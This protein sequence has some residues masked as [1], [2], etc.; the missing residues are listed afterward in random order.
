[1]KK[2]FL[3]ILLPF[4]ILSICG[5]APIIVGAAAGSLGAYALSKDTVQGNTDK[6]Y[7]ALWDSALNVARL[8][9]LIQLE[10]AVKGNIEM[11]VGSSRVFIKLTRLTQNATQLR[12]AARKF[13]FPNM[14]LAQD[15]FVKIINGVK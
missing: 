7:N 15:V 10:D 4:L 13:H 14:D 3:F 6:D 12:V 8:Y 9:G 2:L 1:M 5:C 11:R